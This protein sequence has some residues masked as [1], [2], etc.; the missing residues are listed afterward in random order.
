MQP[1][2]RD[3]LRAGHRGTA[4]G[5][6][7]PRRAH[8]RLRVRPG[9]ARGHRARPPR[10]GVQGAA[11]PGRGGSEGGPAARGGGHLQSG[12]GHR[13]GRG[14][15]GGAG[16]VPA[17][18][19]LRPAA[20]RPRGA[21]GGRGLHRRGVPQV[22]GRPGAGGRGHR[23]DAHR[24]DRVPAGPRQPA[25]RPGTA[26]RRDDRH[27]HLAAGRPAR[28]GPPRGAVR[29]PARVGLHG[30]PGHARRPLPVR[31]LRGAAPARGVGP[32]HRRDHRPPRRPAAGR[33]LRGHDPRP[34]PLR[35]VPRGLRP[36]EGRWSGRR[37]GRGDGLRVPRGRRLHARHQFLAHRGH[38]PRPGPRLPGAGRAGPTALLEGR[39]TGPAA[40]A[41]PRGGRLPARGGRA[42]QGRRPAAARRGGAG[43]LGR[44]Q[45]AV[46]PRRA[47]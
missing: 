16:G 1:A 9:R 21:P 41:R 35:G 10:F 15:P 12:A 2:Q 47:A 13:H 39:P 17:V 36:E 14:G 43:R 8:G 34:G 24:G 37:A 26:A 40:G 44:G 31:R 5:T 25:R 46:L 30:R 45:R 38:H 32:G 28:P 22:P 6:P 33:H 18:R 29:L 7:L 23:A 42:V 3:R 4:G 27:G 20:G 11:R 19:R